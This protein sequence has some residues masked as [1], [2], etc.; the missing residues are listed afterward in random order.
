[1][2]QFVPAIGNPEAAAPRGLQRMSPKN[3]RAAGKGV[4]EEIR[5][6]DSKW[7]MSGYALP[8]DRLIAAR[9]RVDFSTAGRHIW[10]LARSDAVF[11]KKVTSNNA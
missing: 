3:G 2:R 9:I 7:G 10:I 5:Q 1:M 11:P 4:G 6:W 8:G